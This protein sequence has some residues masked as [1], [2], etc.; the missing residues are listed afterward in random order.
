[1]NKKTIHYKLLYTL[2]I[3][4][5]LLTN[6]KNNKH[7]NINICFK[8]SKAFYLP[9]FVHTDQTYCCSAYEQQQPA[10]ITSASCTHQTLHNTRYLRFCQRNFINMGQTG[11]I[12][13]SLFYS[14][15]KTLHIQHNKYHYHCSS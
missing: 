9:H 2:K 15:V 4:K 10:S 7:Q 12:A 8:I 3:P 1:M 14:A 6:A 5:F 11:S 13:N